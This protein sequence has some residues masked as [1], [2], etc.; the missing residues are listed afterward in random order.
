MVRKRK[1]NEGRE[2][3]RD[4]KGQGKNER[5]DKGSKEGSG[6]RKRASIVWA[7]KFLVLSFISTILT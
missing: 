2:M 3:K 5:K 4:L 6:R 7:L 1:R